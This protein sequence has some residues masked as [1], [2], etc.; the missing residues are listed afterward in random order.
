MLFAQARRKKN[1]HGY[2]NLALIKIARL[3]LLF[4][5]PAPPD[6]HIGNGFVR[7]P[8]L[9]FFLRHWVV[10]HLETSHALLSRFWELP[11]QG[12]VRR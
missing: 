5:M 6:P 12:Y 9:N 3:Q 10:T 2:L 4:F 1:I 7:G 8:R 11:L